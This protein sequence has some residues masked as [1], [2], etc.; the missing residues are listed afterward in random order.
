MQQLV[1]TKITEQDK[2]TIDIL[3][4]GKF[5]GSRS[6]LVRKAIDRLLETHRTELKEGLLSEVEIEGLTTL[7][8]DCS[9]EGKLDWKK[10]ERV[11]EDRFFYWPTIKVVRA[12]RILRSLLIN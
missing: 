12:K 8:D 3:I 7:V 11:F 1:Q 9:V 4:E 2:E 6:D 10:V 5:Y